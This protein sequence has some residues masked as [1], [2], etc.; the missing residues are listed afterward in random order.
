ML[1]LVYFRGEK[2]LTRCHIIIFRTTVTLIGE[3]IKSTYRANISVIIF[4]YLFVH[5]SLHLLSAIK[6]QK[7]L[8][9]IIFRSNFCFRKTYET[10]LRLEAFTDFYYYYGIGFMLNATF[11]SRYISGTR[12][13]T[14]KMKKR[15]N[16][17]GKG[18]QIHLMHF[19]YSKTKKIMQFCQICMQICD[20]LQ[21]FPTFYAYCNN[22]TRRQSYFRAA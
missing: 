5:F 9:V 3:I 15:G 16:G 14:K 11:E 6:L 22:Y 10:S 8:I 21:I 18:V 4:I 2:N 1:A 13:F 20:S 19:P 7:S 17:K 12:E